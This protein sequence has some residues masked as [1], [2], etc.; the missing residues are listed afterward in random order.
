LNPKKNL[1]GIGKGILKKKI[2]VWLIPVIGSVAGTALIGLAVFALI[3][4]PMTNVVGYVQSA[5]SSFGEWVSNVWEKAGNWVAGHG[6]YD[7]ETAFQEE[8]KEKYNYYKSKGAIIKTSYIMAT[9]EMRYL[10]TGVQMELGEIED[11]TSYDYIDENEVPEGETSDNIMPFGKMIPDMIRLVE[12]MVHKEYS[13]PQI[14][15]DNVLIYTSPPLLVL[16]GALKAGQ[17][18]LD[19]VPNN[20]KVS[21]ENYLYYLRFGGWAHEGGIKNH[22]NVMKYTVP[23]DEE[24]ASNINKYEKGY[25]ARAFAPVLE[26]LEGEEKA[27]KIESI[28]KD[29]YDLAETLTDYG[30]TSSGNLVCLGEYTN[31]GTVDIALQDLNNVYVNL[32]NCSCAQGSLE[33]CDSWQ[34]QNIPFK[35]YIMGV[36]WGESY[37]KNF[38]AVKAQMVATK[39]YTLGRIKSMGRTWHEVDGKYII[40]MKNCT[41]DQ[42]FV[43]ITTGGDI[44]ERAGGPTRMGVPAANAED[45]ALLSQAY[46]E[47]FNDFIWDGNYFAGPYCSNFGDCDFCKQGVCFAQTL[48]RN[49]TNQ[50]YKQIL[51]Y[52][53]SDFNLLDLSSKTIQVSSVSCPAVA[54]TGQIRLPIDEGLYTVTSPFGTRTSPGGIG[55]INHKGIDMGANLGTPIYAIAPGKV[56]FSGLS[57]GYGYLVTL[58]HDIDANGTYDYYTLYA[59]CSELL[60][61]EGDEISGGTLI[62]K[63]GNTGNS[64][65]PH[66]HFEIQDGANS[67]S[68]AVDPQPFLD[69]IKA[70]T[71]VFNQMIRTEKKYYNQADYSNVAYC[72][73]MVDN[74]GKTSTIQSSG[75]L[76]TSFAM[77]VAALKD[78]T[79]T[80]TTVAN[81]ICSNYRHYRGEGSGTN[82]TILNDTSF[83]SQYSIQSTHVTSDYE[84]QIKTALENNK[85]I[86]VNVKGG[87]FNPSSGGHFF[88]LSGINNDGTV[89]VYDPGSRGR[90]K[91]YNI[92][93][94]ID[95]ISTGIWIFE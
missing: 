11:E 76:P 75:C 71:S 4:G 29:I 38:E 26:G 32:A 65:G 43:P 8:L 16:K 60:V 1:K 22:T 86:I 25:I 58:A 88:V 23:T 85:I 69:D 74:N 14:N 41:D 24:I 87:I 12:H 48:A 40:Y 53:Y 72:S 35:D 17:S 79:V 39:S 37:S 30:E 49:T 67:S 21:N 5:A 68:S 91:N 28:I 55:S 18:L 59:H 31:A 83:L 95:D 19:L 42:V 45:Q 57:G 77:V 33:S 66:L 6:W 27:R 13:I 61:N 9:L 80:P 7:D 84:N 90:T 3:F 64:T 73:G 46:D 44:I 15:S 78:A 50:T 52:H 93:D 82:Q 92:S 56:I 51:G 89:S 81:N 10:Y 47:T 20:T 62:A 63:V 36:V 54:G 34:Y 70:G 2:M 94:F